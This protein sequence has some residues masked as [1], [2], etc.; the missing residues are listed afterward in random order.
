VL[1]MALVAGAGE[2]ITVALADGAEIGFLAGD[3]GVLRP[4]TRPRLSLSHLDDG[5]WV[6]ADGAG[7]GAARWRFDAAGTLTGFARGRS[8]VSVERSEGK[9]LALVEASSGRRV[10]LSWEE[11]RVSSATSSDGRV[12]SYA[13]DE[14]GQ[15]VG[16]SRP[17]GGVSYRI[18]SGLVVAVVD[19]DGVELV[20]N[21]YD[22]A[23]RV[24]SQ[25]SAFGRV[26][27]YAYSD[28]GL[29][30]VT[31][32]AGSARNAFVHDRRGNLTSM[33]DAYGRAMRMR[34]D[35]AGRLVGFTERRGGTWETAWDE[36]GSRPVRRLGPEGFEESFE[37][38]GSGRIVAHHLPS[39]TTRW[40]YS[41]PEHTT[42]S[43]IVDPGGASTQIEVSDD[44][45]ALSVT[46]ADGV[47]SEMSYDADGQLVSVA[48][49]LGNVTRLSYDAYGYLAAW[50]RPSSITVSYEADAAGRVLRAITPKARWSYEWSQAGRALAGVDPAEGPW[51][52]SFGPHGALSSISDPTGAQTGFTYDASGNVVEIAGADG[53]L[54]RQGFDGLSQLV[55]VTDPGG[56]T[57]SYEH[58]PEGELVGIVE[59]TGVATRRV[60]DLLG[61]TTE[62]AD[63]AGRTWRRSYGADGR[64]S[65]VVDPAGWALS[66]RWDA[67]GRLVEV[68]DPGGV[69][70]QFSWSAAG[71]LSSRR[72]ASGAE[73]RFGYDA[74]GRLVGVA[75]DE[76]SLSFVLDV[77]GRVARAVDERGRV[78]VVERDEAGRVTRVV[79]RRGRV[80]HVD[81]DEAGRPRRAGTG[82]VSAAFSYDERG[83]LGEAADPL[84]AATRFSY[85]RAGRIASATDPLGGTTRY[86]Y[87]P[88]GRLGSVTDALGGTSRLV[89]DPTGELV[90]VA[91]PG[92]GGRRRWVDPSGATVGFSEL[93]ASSPSVTVELDP[94]GRPVGLPS[95]PG[96]AR[97]ARRSDPLELPLDEVG[98]VSASPAGD[99]YRHDAD[100]QLVEWV[101]PGRLAVAYRYDPGGRLVSEGTGSSEISY[102]HDAL[103]R[104]L[105][106]VDAGGQ[107]TT[108]AYDAAGE[109]VSEESA[110][111]TVAYAWDAAG[112]LAGIARDGAATGISFDN[113]GFPVSVGGVEVSW[114]LTGA[115]P[116]VSGIGEVSYEWEGEALFAVGPDGSREPVALDWAGSAGEVADPWGTSSGS[117][118][119][120]GYRGELCVDHLVWLGARPY[121]PFT[122]SFLAPDPLPNPPGAPCAAN[123]YHYAWNDPVSLVDPS[124][125]RPLTQDEFNQRKHA[126]EL[127]HL[128]QAWEAIKKDPWGSVALG[129]TVAAGVGLLFVPGGQ[130]IGAGILIGVA[131]SSG[132]G[133]A[134]GTFD[135]RMAAFNGVI[136][137]ITG[138]VGSAFSGAGVATQVALGA[139]MGGGGNALTQQVF[140]GHVDWSQ[141]AI[142]TA[143]GGVGAG[144]GAK[145]AAAREVNA[146]GGPRVTVYRGT[147][148]TSEVQIHAETGLLMS[149]AA[150]IG[151]VESGGSIAAARAAS[152][153]AHAAG[154][155]AW[156]SEAA[157]AQAHS[158][159]GT[160][161][162]QVGRRSMISVTTDPAVAKMF[163]GPGGSV[164]SATVHPATLIP[165]TLPGA[166]ESEYLIAH[167][168]AAR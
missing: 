158:A 145:I 79:D 148:V 71:R 53:R 55:S 111:G 96:T 142:S 101:A 88:A 58:D 108:Y 34:Y 33:V 141:V 137:G 3:D 67:S 117:G 15:L 167:M 149:D 94:A 78:L 150:R 115:W 77:D 118:V 83:L 133:I 114:D 143:V 28:H 84:G 99:A 91:W 151:Y 121:D 136:G 123:P 104:L 9:V 162:S 72:D 139:G 16:V 102:E 122:R 134:T 22:E 81:L 31:D 20:A 48:D 45:L 4:E 26:S 155:E 39:G 75:D 21:V 127:G 27:A 154:I 153:A 50:R 89:R 85:D 60:V 8:Q 92:G 73:T 90:G 64:L 32:E 120:L 126:E 161:I 76:G 97:T 29:T 125:L 44:D 40:S 131:I 146:G 130:A 107:A 86:G 144:A 13:Y 56:S 95:R 147:S 14:E 109:R 159:F 164:F 128:G 103:G 98:R 87:D 68:A 112:R 152:E 5:T 160:E 82:P 65:E 38:D 23:G 2:G 35:A 132:A 106:R 163:A 69:L 42:P 116:R 119:R 168:F 129:L 61:R 157:Y 57:W 80:R 18:G 124:G 70:G 19:A 49:A 110:S 36:A 66:Y 51:R 138:G 93:G 12:V 59:P 62:E 25:R 113:L 17:S 52:A 47:R 63:A 41:A 11:G 10:S 7:P 156:G 100:G 46:D 105:R 165:Q 54:Y 24:A 74:A 30:V 140:T 1:D 6:L 135:P 166:G 37:W 43:L